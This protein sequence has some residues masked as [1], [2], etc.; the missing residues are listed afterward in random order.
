MCVCVCVC[1]C[2][3]TFPETMSLELFRLRMYARFHII[4]KE[5]SMY[6]Y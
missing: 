6:D 3:N 5:C 1:V 4:L 2:V